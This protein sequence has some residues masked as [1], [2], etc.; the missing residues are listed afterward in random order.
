MSSKSS[1]TD[2]I[3]FLK[4]VTKYLY[5]FGGPILISVGSVSCILSLIVFTKK[6]LRKNPCSIYFIAYNVANFILIYSS[7]FSVSLSLGYGIAPATYNLAY[8]RYN[9][10]MAILLDVLSSSYL[11]LAS[12]DRMLVTSLNVHTRQRSTR[13]LTCIC[14]ISVTVCWI[15]FHSHILFSATI[16]QTAPNNFV[17]VL[18][19]GIN[20]ILHSYYSLIVKAFLIPLFMTIFGLLALKNIRRLRRNTVAPVLT[21]TGTIVRGHLQPRRSKDRQ[22]ALMLFIDISTYIIFSFMLSVILMYQQITQYDVKSPIQ[23]QFGLF[24]K[25][26]ATFIN[27]IST[28]IGCY[29]NILISKTFRKSIKDIVLCN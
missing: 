8:C 23:T 4:L 19:S 15:L 2:Y 22:F 17:C 13:R 16:E 5:E 29:T 7:I 26:L 12:I 11:V 28:C 20:L 24:L 6:D 1:S 27:Y 10:Y 9:L 18:P 25:N 3:S 21:T 14:I